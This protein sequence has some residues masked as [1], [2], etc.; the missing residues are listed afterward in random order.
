MNFTN[1]F[2]PIWSPLISI[3]LLIGLFGLGKIIIYNFKLKY[4]IFEVSDL[5]YQN[6]MIGSIFLSSILFPL[7]IFNIFDINILIKLTSFLLLLLAIK[8]IFNF[9]L[10]KNLKIHKPAFQ[11]PTSILFLFLIG[12]FLL[13]LAPVTNA[14]S[15]D[16]HLGVPLYMLNNNEYP[17]YKFWTHFTKSGSGELLNAVG[18]IIKAEQFPS[19]I[20][21]SGILSIYGIIKKNHKKY[22]DLYL[23]LFLSSPILI[24]LVSS[25]KPQL[26]YIG[27]SGLIFSLLF[28]SNEKNFQH[29]GFILFILI[30][31]F[32]NINA[33]FS[34]ALSSFLFFVVI[35]YYC[36]RNN[37]ILYLLL[38]SIFIFIFTYGLKIIWKMNVY[39]M[40]LIEATFSPLPTEIYGYQ[41]LYNSL[42]SCGYEGCFPSW[43]IFPTSLNTIT[44]ALGLGSILIIFS[45]FINNSKNKIIICVIL[46]YIIIAFLYGQNNP[47]WF[48]ELFTWLIITS[49]FF[50]PK[51]N[52]YIKIFFNLAKFQGAIV[53]LIILYG[54]FTLTPGVL[55]NELRDKVLINSANGYE[56]FKWSNSKMKKDDVLI[57]THRSFSLSNVKTIPGDL[58]NYIDISDDRAK[59][60][61]NEIKN[62]K[63]THIIFY[64]DKKN[65][66]K[67]SK[68]LGKL[69]FYNPKAGR[70]TARNPLN[71]RDSFY[72]G[73]IYKFNH[74]KLPDCLTKK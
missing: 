28:F 40:S 44:E 23:L 62:L 34:F 18:L 70:F 13:S 63:P 29:K 45:K 71:K 72:P 57:S 12:Y 10:K 11:Q 36:Y 53:F 5:N 52:N 31:L 16:Y 64:N 7:V 37:R 6:I 32:S 58:F 30:L 50:G 68:C 26:S 19:L 33:K 67:F 74:L 17:A 47:R 55:S 3:V 43:L 22:N 35:F 20:Q 39:E 2:V 14:D 56:L 51:N 42:T 9:F 65:F 66:E 59:I 24:L 4:I 25:A 54:I 27:S 73:Y 48:F 15:L 8:E 21:F 60:H 41:Q 46:L 49:K 61:F 38:I 69:V 1:I